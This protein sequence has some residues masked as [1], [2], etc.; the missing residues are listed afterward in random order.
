MKKKG[1]ELEP[2]LEIHQGQ[3]LF[4]DLGRIDGAVGMN[5][6]R[7]E[8]GPEPEKVACTCPAGELLGLR[9]Y[10]S[11]YPDYQGYDRSGIS[12][13]EST[14]HVAPAPSANIEGGTPYGYPTEHKD[15]ADD[16]SHLDMTQRDDP[17][18]A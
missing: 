4:T 2:I 1:P 14:R 15:R 11:D 16:D 8:I 12:D 9:D 5:R 17:H 6:V 3:E 7:A 13:N 10:C 18:K